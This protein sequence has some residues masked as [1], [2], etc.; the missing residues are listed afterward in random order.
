MSWFPVG[1]VCVSVCTRALVHVDM[2]VF[3]CLSVSVRGKG[4]EI[5]GPL[6]TSDSEP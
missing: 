2:C 6:S 1:C 4:V 5:R 3:V